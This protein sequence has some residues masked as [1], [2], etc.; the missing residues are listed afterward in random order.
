[1]RPLTSAADG[2]PSA[3]LSIWVPH[4][5]IR[6]IWFESQTWL[7][8]CRVCILIFVKSWPYGKFSILLWFSFTDG[9]AVG[10]SWK[11]SIFIK[12]FL[13]LKKSQT[14]WHKPVTL[15]LGAWG[16]HRRVPRPCWSAILAE[17]VGFIFRETSVTKEESNRKS[18][19]STGLHVHSHSQVHQ[20]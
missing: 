15:V 8:C 10:V 13:E 20:M 16:R 17:M 7:L 14:W 1:M 3:L 5:P 12:I 4:G 9:H 11:R 18:L 2:P 6:R 19:K